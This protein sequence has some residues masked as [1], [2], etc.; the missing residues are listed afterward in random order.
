MYRADDD[1]MHAVYPRL[2]HLERTLPSSK[3]AGRNTPYLCGPLTTD[4]T[5]SCDAP[6]DGL[7]GRLNEAW[8]CSHLG[9]ASPLACPTLIKRQ[10]CS[11]FSESDVRKRSSRY[12]L[13][14]NY[15]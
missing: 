2:L 6:A 5:S 7:R 14:C 11:S 3:K 4:W 1:Y 10:I 13:D 9:F 8:H 12:F 15:N